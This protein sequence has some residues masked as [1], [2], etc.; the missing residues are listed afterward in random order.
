MNGE[1]A[2]AHMKPDRLGQLSHGLQ[3][4]KCVTLYAPA[5]FL[6]E[7]SGHRVGDRI[8]VGRDVQS[9]PFQIVSRVHD[10]GEFVALRRLGAGPQRTLRR[11][12]RR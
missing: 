9:P 10:E 4:K 3:A 7:Q 12:C 11:P 8:Q 6:A 2:V 1:I 5:A